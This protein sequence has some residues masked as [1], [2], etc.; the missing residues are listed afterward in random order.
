M[1]SV[2]ESMTPEEAPACFYFLQC[3]SGV[4]TQLKEQKKRQLKQR[5]EQERER[6]EAMMPPTRASSKTSLPT[7][8]DSTSGSQL[9]GGGRP[10]RIRSGSTLGSAKGLEKHVTASPRSFAKFSRTFSHGSQS[11]RASSARSLSFLS[12]ESVPKA[13]RQA[14]QVFQRLNSRD[15]QDSFKLKRGFS[16]RSMRSLQRS[17]SSLAQLGRSVSLEAG[18]L[19]EKAARPLNGVSRRTR[20]AYSLVADVMNRVEAKMDD[21]QI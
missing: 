19:A 13:A 6:M 16:S 1:A 18:A 21:L 4:Q 7:L 14:T 9:T 8:L 11:S 12:E 17:S 5:K 2:A 15:S 20:R 3:Y 10:T